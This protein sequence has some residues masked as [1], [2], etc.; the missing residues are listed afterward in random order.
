MNAKQEAKLNMYTTVILL[1]E[2]NPAI[3]ALLVAFQ[4]TYD[5]FKTTV[6]AINTAA[7][8]LEAQTTGLAVTKNTAKKNLADIG[9]GMAGLVYA[10]AA[11]IKDDTLKGAM[12]ISYS[13]INEAKDDEVAKICQ[14]IYTAANNNIAAL[15]DYGL[16]PAILTVYQNA[17]NGYSNAAPQPRLS[18]AEKKAIRANMVT[19]FGDAD[20]LLKEQLDKTA[21]A[22]RANGNK[23]FLDKYLAARV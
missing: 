18:I 2:N 16:T 8:E 5:A 22:F 1:C 3:V 19:L 15:A 7:A 14:N 17:I 12:K 20:K 9:S 13:D 11:S 6:K 10:Y 21:E 23:A 4:T